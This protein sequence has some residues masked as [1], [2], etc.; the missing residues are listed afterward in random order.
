LI[1][2]IYAPSFLI[3]NLTYGISVGLAYGWLHSSSCSEI[4][5]A[6]RLQR[7]AVKTA[8]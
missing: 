7:G 1:L 2:E 5:A 6:R 4:T 3:Q 8:R